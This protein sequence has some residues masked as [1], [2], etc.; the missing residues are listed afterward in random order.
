[1]W[2]GLES[3]LLTQLAQTRLCRRVGRLSSIQGMVLHATGLDARLG[4]L[5][6]IQPAQGGEAVVAEVVGLRSDYTLLMP[7]APVD[8][9]CLASE[10]HSRG[11]PYTVPVGDGLLG[12][13]LDATC[14]PLDDRPAPEGVKRMPRFVA[15]INPL[16]RSPITTTLVTGVKA[17]DVFTPLGRGQR[18]GIF[19]GSGVG[20]STLLGMMS[21]YAEADVIV[22]ALIGERGREV[23]DFIRESLGPEGL[24]KAVVIAA[25]AEQ[26]AVLRRQAAYTATTI[27]EWFRAQGKHV[28]LIMDSITR[29]AL[30]QREIG[31]ST[32]E[33]M[34][35]RGYTPSVFALLPPLMER[36][37]ALDG[38]GSITGVYTVLVEGDDMNEPVADHM[39][40]ILDGHI[41][42][43]RSV[44][45]RGHWPA[46]EVLHSISR[47]AGALHT[48]EQ[49]SQV[50]RLRSAL[51]SYQSSADLIE[52]GAYEKG[53]Q[54]LLDTMIELKSEFDALLQQTPEEHFPASGTWK[55]VLELVQRLGK[56]VNSA[57]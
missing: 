23:G 4:E 1:M 55:T 46:I 49:K 5:V 16:H 14:N 7:Y 6:D 44:A 52:L 20:K 13:V 33:P 37:G 2:Q 43:S 38:Q 26:P 57:R 48:H 36:A 12:R 24:K 40:A 19:A 41:V 31:L 8:G 3:R 47:L 17:V 53:S 21:K 25:A 22:I 56:G 29:F 30:A 35:S 50:E 39:R 9:L 15:P 34:G 27:A 54:P 18:I 28:L 11:A 42:L 45:A 32:G 51:G 10:V